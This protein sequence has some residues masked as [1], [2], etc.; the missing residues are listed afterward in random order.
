MVINN[1]GYTVERVIHGPARKYNDIDPWNYQA[2]LQFFGGASSEN[3]KSHAARTYEEL[4][5]VLSNP[6]FQA[7]RHIQVLECVLDR[8]DSPRLLSEL[9][10][11]NAARQ[12]VVMAQ[13]D[14]ANKR[15]RKKIDGTLTESGLSKGL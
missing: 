1:N 11:R 3:T 9:V 10:D 2:M 8:Y 13:D 15:E 14:R 6:D 12:A 7:S 5:A 4:T